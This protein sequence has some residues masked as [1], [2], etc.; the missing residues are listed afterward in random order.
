MPQFC[1]KMLTVERKGVNP[2]QPQAILWTNRRMVPGKTGKTAGQA[3]KDEPGG[4]RT[5]SEQEALNGR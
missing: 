3:A 5:A 1:A 4:D 2:A